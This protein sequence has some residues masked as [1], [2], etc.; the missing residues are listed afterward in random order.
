MQTDTRDA[1]RRAIAAEIRAEMARQNMTQRQLA[2]RVGIIQQALQLRLSGA[3][4]FRAEELAAVATALGV[5]VTQL[6]PAAQP[7]GGAR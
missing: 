4:S 1:E 3:R 2:E 7:T 6:L 5:P